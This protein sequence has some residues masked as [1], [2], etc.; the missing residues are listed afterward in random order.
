MALASAFVAASWVAI[1]EGE[2]EPASPP[3]G[4]LT[5]ETLVD[6]AA[7]RN[8]Q[9]KVSAAEV[10][11]AM[12]L[13]KA[14][15][16][17]AYPRLDL[18]TIFGGPVPEAKTRVVND[19][20]T[21]TPESIRDGSLNFGE[22]GVT[23]RGDARIIQPLYTFGQIAKGKQATSHLV[24][25][26]RQQ[27]EVTTAEVVLNVH[28]AFWTVQLVRA[29]VLPLQESE[30]I[31]TRIVDQIEELLDAESD[32]VTENDRLRINHA[33]AT[34]R[35]RL[36]EAEVGL[37]RANQALRLLCNLPLEVPL[38]VVERDMYDALP[39]SVPA[40]DPLVAIARAE[41]PA[42][43]ALR[44]VVEAQAD[45]VALRRASL[46]PSFFIGGL[47]NFAY[48]SNATDQTNPFIFDPYN[49]LDF[50]LGV[51]LVW[52][53]DLFTKTAMIERA[54]AEHRVR[55]QQEALATS[56]VEL[57]VRQLHAQLE[58]GFHQL[59]RLEEANRAARGWL[60]SAVLAF[61]IGSGDARNLTDA[62]LAFAASEG[63]LQTVRYNTVVRT[64]ELARAIGRL[65]E[66][67]QR[68]R[69]DA[70]SP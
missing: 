25:A 47:V 66:M 17:Q 46:F 44:Q 70:F 59:D 31:F 37:E 54:D 38:D 40:I 50:G 41:R 39:E 9:V 65:R 5:L 45:L 12:A 27:Q 69:K 34:V 20:S 15:A 30:E 23:V 28:R 8:Q 67:H 16:A 61:D 60:T 36:A 32:Q 22:L 4:P 3:A 56:A 18:N 51:G 29:F 53:F 58:G 10:E 68:S 64:A 7:R 35:A 24:D 2:P 13:A 63:E 14:A 21:A 49:T 48:T 11:A 52:E 57:E 33:L 42:L 43:L 6:L 1:A 19:P 62:F 55:I 26:S